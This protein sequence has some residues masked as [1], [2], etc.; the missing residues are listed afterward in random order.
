VDWFVPDVGMSN[1]K[2]DCPSSVAFVVGIVL[3]LFKSFGFFVVLQLFSQC[4]D[5]F[6]DWSR[7]L[8]SLEAL[9]VDFVQ[10]QV[11]VCFRDCCQFGQSF[12]DS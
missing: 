4:W 3:S 7:M 5:L 1:A 6:G 8:E 11:L 12:A 10:R 9:W 2:A